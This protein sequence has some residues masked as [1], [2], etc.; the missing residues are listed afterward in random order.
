MPHP[1]GASVAPAE[2]DQALAAIRDTLHRI[3]FGSIAITVHDGRIVQLDVKNNVGRGEENAAHDRRNAASG[4]Q[5]R[6]L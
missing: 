1:L 4:W 2:P 6:N 3:R 5:S